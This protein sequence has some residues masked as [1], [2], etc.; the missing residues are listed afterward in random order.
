[1][2]P[3][4]AQAD[5]LGWRV[6]HRV[7]PFAC[8]TGRA[9]GDRVAVPRLGGHGFRE[10]SARGRRACRRPAAGR[11]RRRHARAIARVRR[12]PAAGGPG[13]DLGGRCRLVVRPPERADAP[14]GAAA[15]PLPDPVPALPVRPARHAAAAAARRRLARL[16][17]EAARRPVHPGRRA[18]ARA[19]ALVRR[20]GEDSACRHDGDRLH[21]ADLRDDRRH[22]LLPRAAALGT[23]ARCRPS[24]WRA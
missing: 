10:P 14:A 16:V 2:C 5:P 23:V 18:H 1:M 8:A 6:A 13:A 12:A 4:L 21:H 22:D 17:A 11:A 20:A 24:A 9:P 3:A 15:R 19:G 7:R